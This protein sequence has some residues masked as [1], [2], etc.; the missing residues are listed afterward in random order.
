MAAFIFHR[1]PLETRQ[2]RQTFTPSLTSHDL[3][4]IA[5]QLLLYLRFYRQPICSTCRKF[6]QLFNLENTIEAT[7]V[8]DDVCYF[9]RVCTDIGF[10]AGGR[11]VAGKASHIL[12]WRFTIAGSFA[13]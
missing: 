8:G 5:V 12:L 6:V 1:F 11:K 10:G 9:F 4:T 7:Y 2:A 13:G 3:T